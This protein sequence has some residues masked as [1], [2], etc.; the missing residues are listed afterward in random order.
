MVVISPLQAL[1][2]EL[3]RV[4]PSAVMCPDGRWTRQ[5]DDY[6]RELV[7]NQKLIAQVKYACR[8]VHVNLQNA[9]GHKYG[10]F[11]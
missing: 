11:Y 7:L 10:T 5:A 2:C 9:Y 8:L 3:I 4:R 1:E 6:F